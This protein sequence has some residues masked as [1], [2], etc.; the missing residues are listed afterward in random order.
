MSDLTNANIITLAAMKRTGSNAERAAAEAEIARRL[1]PMHPRMEKDRQETT[2]EG[3][4]LRGS[5]QAS[6]EKVMDAP[7]IAPAEKPT[8]LIP[9]AE[10]SEP[11]T[12]TD[13][14]ED[15]ITDLKK[16]VERLHAVV[17]AA[18]IIA[19]RALP[20]ADLAD[21]SGVLSYYLFG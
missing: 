3:A 19:V 8:C 10:P 15:Q 6:A 5:H 16:H 21:V 7:P 13:E 14:L 11:S 4:A 12:D 18:S 9:P 17:D 2:S 20:S 1:S